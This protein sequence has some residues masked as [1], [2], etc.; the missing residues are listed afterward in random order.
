[1]QIFVLAK[2]G[3]ALMP[4]HPAR[5]RQLL[6]QGRAVIHRT[7]PFVIR[8]KERE[9]GATQPLRLKIDPGSKVT[10]IALVRETPSADAM[11]LGLM[12]LKH[13]GW[14]ISEALT[15]RRNM[16]RRRRSQLRYRAPRFLN[17]RNK[18][19]G[20]LA[21]SLQHRVDTTIAWAKRLQRWAPITAISAELS[22]FDT[23]ALQNPEISGIEYQQGTLFGYE[24]REY[25]LEK[26]NRQCAYCGVKVM[27]LQIEHIQPK[28]RGGSNRISNLT[29]ACPCCNTKKGAQS[30]E[31]F[32]VKKPEVLRRVLAQA[33]HPLKDAATMN[34]TRWALVRRLQATGLP[35]ELSSGGRTKFNRSRLA[36]PKSSALDAACVGQFASIKNWQRPT[37]EIKCTGRGK[38]QRTTLNKFGFP[39]AYL[40][41]K[42]QVHGFQ[43]GDM[44]KS[45][46]P[47]GK[48][49]GLHRGRIAVRASGHFDI[50]TS[51][52]TVGG[53]SHR[54]CTLIQRGD[55]YGYFFITKDSL[56]K[57]SEG[58]CYPSPS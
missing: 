15:A 34:A 6:K 45:D 38:Y 44:V 57:G 25:L 31:Q 41:K 28:A 12:E 30:V 21:P 10:G 51:Q 50:Q 46:V 40:M 23:Q 11:V 26:W 24:V 8:L 43:T 58:R 48:K 3:Q 55:G 27:P 39:R 54:Y 52:G 20:W 4:C 47:K 53:I 13:R 5:A 56:E 36:V 1:M 14:Q 19:A 18:K 33:K 35:V 49:A 32:L 29:L 42:K 7:M 16:R 37:L 2:N 17:R 9:A 22:R